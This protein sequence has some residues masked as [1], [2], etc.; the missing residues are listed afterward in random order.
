MA[1]ENPH[2]G[3]GAQLLKGDGQ[4]PQNF[5]AVMGIK[6]INGPNI[7]RDTHDTTD[8]NQADNYRTFIGGLVD[9][10]EV[11]FDANLLLRDGTQN[12]E[13][14]GYMAEFDKPSCDSRGDWRITLPPCAGDPDGYLEFSGIVTGQQM[15][16]PLDD[17]MS[18]AGTI[19]VSG[20]PEV[21]LIT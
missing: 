10:G 8:M 4:S 2:T 13:T 16:I 6:S 20:R 15:Q 1:D 7:Q 11:S 14:G 9:G 3:M 18:F 17:I 19:K 5:V 12:Q 21:V